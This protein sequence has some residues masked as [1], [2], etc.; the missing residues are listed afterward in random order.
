MHKVLKRLGSELLLPFH[1]YFTGFKAAMTEKRF[2]FI[3]TIVLAFIAGWWMYVPVH[4]LFHAFGCIL[5]GGEVTRLEISEIYGA[6]LLSK[7]FPFISV[8]SEYAGRLTGF[9]TYDNDLIYLLTVFFPYL[10]TIFIG[11]PLL[12]YVIYGSGRSYQRCLWFGLS[13]PVAYAPFISMTGDYY[14]MASII[15]TGLVSLFFPD[16]QVDRWRS[17]DLIRLLDELVF[18]TEIIR[19]GDIFGIIFSLFL[20]II[21]IFLT[22]RT[23]RF[24]SYHAF[25][26]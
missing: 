13:L 16:F 3:I 17:D 7:V 15:V 20:G 22:Y 24:W 18:S 23:G 25:K 2:A 5:G 12:Q 21:M 1:D 6:A 9:E 10:L 19:T 11:V 26:L 8:G 4:E 14:E